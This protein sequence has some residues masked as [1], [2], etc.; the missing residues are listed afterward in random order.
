MTFM[1]SIDG[2]DRAKVRAAGSLAHS[3]AAERSNVL[4]VIQ[5]LSQQP[6]RR[7]G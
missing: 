1:T 3:H 4:V 5:S 2:S 7:W 6:I